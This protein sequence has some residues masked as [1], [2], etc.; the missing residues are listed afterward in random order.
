[1]FCLTLPSSRRACLL[2]ISGI[3]ATVSLAGADQPAIRASIRMP[4]SFE[5]DK[6]HR[7]YLSRSA[8]GTL[9]FRNG[10]VVFQK[11]GLKMELVGS[12]PAAQLDGGTETPGQ[13]NYLIGNK[14]GAVAA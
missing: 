2:V 3:I 5:Y 6:E 4:L 14:P 12:N 11:S 13:I 9:L 7:Q 8:S 1:V 10:E